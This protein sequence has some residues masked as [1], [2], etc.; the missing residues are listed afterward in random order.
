MK[1]GWKVKVV[2]ETLGSVRRGIH[3]E[4]FNDPSKGGR[5]VSPKVQARMP[6]ASLQ[7]CQLLQRAIAGGGEGAQ[8]SLAKVPVLFGSSSSSSWHSRLDGGKAACERCSRRSPLPKGAASQPGKELQARRISCHRPLPH[9]HAKARPPARCFMRQ[10]RVNVHTHSL[11]AKPVPGHLCASSTHLTSAQER[12]PR[13][14]PGSFVCPR[15]TTPPP[16]KVQAQ[17]IIQM[18]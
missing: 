12:R 8:G 7:G 1:I 5:T 2:K 16:E 13:P 15:A 6:S 10:D 9:S 3:P 18:N 11:P 17:M 14:A 4:S